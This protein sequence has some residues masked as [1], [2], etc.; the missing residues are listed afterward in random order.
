MIFFERVGQEDA[1]GNAGTQNV[2]HQPG[3]FQDR[4]AF[5][6]GAQVALIGDALLVEGENVGDGGPGVQ[7]GDGRVA[8]VACG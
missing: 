3:Q 2:A 6:R 1:G 7:H 4:T 8:L 5:G